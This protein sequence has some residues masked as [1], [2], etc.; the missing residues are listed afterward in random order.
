MFQN[1][2]LTPT[3]KVV[4]LGKKKL[5]DRRYGRQSM[6]QLIIA[7]NNEFSLYYSP[8]V[9]NNFHQCN[10]PSQYI[11]TISEKHYTGKIIEALINE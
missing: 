9:K 10:E 5:L 8:H 7:H 4:F 2:S 6:S 3:L 1:S 11:F